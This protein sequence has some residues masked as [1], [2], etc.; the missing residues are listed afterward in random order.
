MRVLIADD[1]KSV[2]TSLAEMVGLCHHQVVEVVSTG[3]EAIQAYDRHRPDVV[4]DGLPD[5]EAERHH[6]LPLHFG[7]GSERACDFNFRLECAGRTRVIRCNRHSLQTRCSAD[8][9]CRAYRCCRAQKE[10]RAGAG[11]RRCDTWPS[12]RLCR[13]RG[14]VALR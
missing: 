6:C 2:G 10:K 3:M 5:A 11:N 4:L 8:T 7:E 14:H 13:A 1:Q 12:G 9:R